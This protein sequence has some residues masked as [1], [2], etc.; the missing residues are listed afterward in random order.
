VARPD[1]GITPERAAMVSSALPA[2]YEHEYQRPVAGAGG[3][4]DDSVELG[5]GE[6]EGD[7]QEARPARGRR[8]RQPR[9]GGRNEVDSTAATE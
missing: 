1:A 5:G 9:E 3:V 8:A 2:D 4:V 7:E 6:Q